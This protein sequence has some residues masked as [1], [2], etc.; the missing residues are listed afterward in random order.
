VFP[1]PDPR[2]PIPLYAQIADRVRLAVATGELSAGK[3]LPSVRRLASQLGVNPATVVQG[4][5]KL[6]EAGVVERRQGAGTFVRELSRPK[7]E[8]E[9]QR[10]ARRLVRG[11]LREAASRGIRGADLERALRAERKGRV[12]GAARARRASASLR[13]PAS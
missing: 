5:R 9:R 6:E 13:S 10:E 12:A 3:A 4:Y 7:R 2:S 8:A 1:R 11:L